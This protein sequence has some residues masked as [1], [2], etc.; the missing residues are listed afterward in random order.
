MA[1]NK[2]MLQYLGEQWLAMMRH[3]CALITV[4]CN[5]RS[6]EGFLGMFQI[7]VQ[8]RHAAF[9]NTSEVAWDER[10]AYCCNK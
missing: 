7:V 6:V 9:E 2:V 1:A 5:T 4:H 10:P 3:H 8:V